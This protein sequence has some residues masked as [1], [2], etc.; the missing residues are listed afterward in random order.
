MNCCAECFG[1]RGLRT[2]IIPS[3]S[4]ELGRCSYCGSDDVQVVA[5]K[6]LA[7]YFWLL[8]NVYRRD[9]DGKLLI[10]WF[11]VDWGLFRHPRMDDAQAKDLVTEILNDLEIVRET[12]SPIVHAGADRLVEWQSLREELMWRNRFFPKANIDLD[13]LGAL[14]SHLIVGAQEITRLWYRARIQTGENPFEIGEMGAPPKRLASYGRANPVG[15]PYLYVASTPKTAISELRPHT[16]EIACVVDFRLPEDL[17]L[18]D[19]RNPRQMVSPFLLEDALEIGRMRSDLP[20]LER[21]GEELT[22]PVAPHAAPI[23]YTP[24]QYL[25]EFIKHCGYDGVVYRSSVSE[26]TN[27]ALFDPTVAIPVSVSRYRVER[28]SV[29]IVATPS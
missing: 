19:L 24:S 20:F 22:R 14:L 10:E 28:V 2:N 17:K 1:D 25:C 11:R 23:D 12:F 15:I 21:L 5:P 13:R 18:V 8:I 7:E 6:Q 29:E 26:G 27:L 16:G 3:L 9:P 4:S